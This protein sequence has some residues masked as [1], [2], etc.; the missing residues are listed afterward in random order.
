MA[1]L[2]NFKHSKQKYSWINNIGNKVKSVAEFVGTA[3]GLYDIG[4]GI[5]S[6]FQVAAPIVA[7]LL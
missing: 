7:G 5:Y 1:S 3:K 6:G 4:R 2:H